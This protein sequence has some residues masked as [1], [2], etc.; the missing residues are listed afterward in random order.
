MQ[1]LDKQTKQKKAVGCKT[2][3]DT[4]PTVATAMVPAGENEEGAK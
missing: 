1:R 3:P 2:Q 4:F